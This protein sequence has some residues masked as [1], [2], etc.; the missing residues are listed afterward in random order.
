MNT[1]GTYSLPNNLFV[2]SV[3]TTLPNGATARGRLKEINTASLRAAFRTPPPNGRILPVSL[4][5]VL[6]PHKFIPLDVQGRIARSD[7]EG[8]VVEFVDVP[9]RSRRHLDRLTQQRAR[10]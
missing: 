7:A 2:L 1:T 9:D 3:E 8:T 10:G 4:V 6:G 5:C